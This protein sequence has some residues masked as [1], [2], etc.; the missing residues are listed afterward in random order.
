MIYTEPNGRLEE[1]WGLKN[2]DTIYIQLTVYANYYSKMYSKCY[3]KISSE[4][5]FMWEKFPIVLRFEFCLF[6]MLYAFKI[7]RLVIEKQYLFAS[8]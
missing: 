7:L 5:E 1:Q 3:C 6:C 4:A 2:Q 8:H